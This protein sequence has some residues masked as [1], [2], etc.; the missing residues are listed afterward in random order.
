MTHFVGECGV[1]KSTK[2]AA[3]IYKRAVELGNSEAN[4][5]LAGLYLAGDGVKKDENKALQLYRVASD[6]GDPHA[7]IKLAILLEDKGSS[8]EETF[9]LLELAAKQGHTDA[10]Y[11]VGFRYAIGH[12][13]TQDL[14]EGKRWLRRAAAKGGE[15]AI[16]A[17]ERISAWERQNAATGKAR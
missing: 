5:R 15:Q 2:K 9:R 6:R 17:L 10:E 1:V 7:R 12:G 16:G 3:K 4:L 8:H 11:N 13:V 14:E